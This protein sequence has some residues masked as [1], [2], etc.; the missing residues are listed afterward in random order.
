MKDP[1]APPLLGSL[2]PEGAGPTLGRPGGWLDVPHAPPLRGS[3]PPE[4]ADPTGGGPA[5]ARLNG[6]PPSPRTT[7]PEGLVSLA[8]HA[9]L[10]RTALSPEAD[11]YFNGGAADETTLRENVAAWQSLRLH[12]RVLRPLAGGHTRVQLLGRTLAHP[13]LIAPMAYQR[14]AHPHG[15]M[16]TALAAAVLGAGFVLSTQASVPLEDVAHTVLGEAERGPLWFQLYLQPDRAFTRDLVHRAEAAGY[17]ALVLTV[18]APVNGARDRER[19]AG[20]ALPPG[21]TAINLQGLRPPKPQTLRPGQSPLFDDLLT[22]A[23]TWDDVAWLRSVTRLPLLLKG[24]TH[25]ADAR[26]A[27][28]TGAQGL[29]VSNHGGRTLDTMPATAELLPAVMQAVGGEVPVLV[30]GG[31]RRGTDVLKAMALGAAAVLVGRPVIHGLANAG[32]TG[33]AHVIRLLRDEVEIAMAL[34]GCQTLAEAAMSLGRPADR[35]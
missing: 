5:P 29:I 18:D 25:P 28:Q 2:P 26:L 27:V 1:H 24:V 15:E 13:V 21:I 3:L 30:D 22:H 33:V 32:A 23:P 6:K 7:L 20:F 12:P 35:H 9:T 11:A 4:G 31:I 16:A 17:E 14:L 10:A 34:C 8:D 19:R